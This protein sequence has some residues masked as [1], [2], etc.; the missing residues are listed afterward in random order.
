M[1]EDPFGR[2]DAEALEYLGMPEGELHHLP[3]PSDLLI[4]APD[5]LV[6]GYAGDLQLGDR[7]AEDGD[8]LVR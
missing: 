8:L 2:V 7:L 5:V 3:D 1:E 4:D 6:G